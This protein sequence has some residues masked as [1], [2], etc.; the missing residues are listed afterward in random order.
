MLARVLT[1]LLIG[2][3]L[4]AAVAVSVP[5]YLG[6]LWFGFGIIFIGMCGYLAFHYAK[7]AILIAKD[8]NKE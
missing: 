4:V 5:Q 1:Y 8:I 7:R 6:Y 2:G 3:L